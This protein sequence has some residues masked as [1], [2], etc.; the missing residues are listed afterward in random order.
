MGGFD[1]RMI[2]G[3]YSTR[4]YRE[5]T[6]DVAYDM[7]NFKDPYVTGA[8]IHRLVQER[9][10]T[11][12]LFREMNAKLDRLITLADGIRDELG[13]RKTPQIPS[14]TERKTQHYFLSE[15]DQSILDFIAQQDRV[16]AADVQRKFGYRGQNAASA[17]L[18]SLYKEGRLHKGRAG[19]KVYYWITEE[20]G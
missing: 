3:Q 5:Y 2:P 18:N 14:Q 9:S 8:M 12:R 15:V 13:T 10:S 1:K 20:R 6:K 11:N 17:R 16:C 7:E 4:E 19:R